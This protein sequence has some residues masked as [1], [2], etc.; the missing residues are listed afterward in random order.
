MKRTSESNGNILDDLHKNR[1]RLISQHGGIAGLAV[2]LRK[3]EATTD[4]KVFSPADQSRSVNVT[5]RQRV[6]RVENGS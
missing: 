4:R 3:Q 1:Q 6:R 5:S 2:Y